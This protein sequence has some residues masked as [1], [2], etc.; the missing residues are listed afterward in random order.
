MHRFP[1]RRIDIV[2]K[3]ATIRYLYHSASAATDFKQNASLFQFGALRRAF[4][5]WCW[6]GS[7]FS[8]ESL[9]PRSPDLAFFFWAPIEREIP[10]CFMNVCWNRFQW[11]L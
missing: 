11:L 1:T 5:V 3:Q 4:H 7:N 8:D 9:N 6:K 10:L 2:T